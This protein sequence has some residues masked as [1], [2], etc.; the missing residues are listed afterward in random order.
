M[1]L[2]DFETKRPRML[3]RGKRVE[4]THVAKILALPLDSEKINSTQWESKREE[5]KNWK[6]QQSVRKFI[7]IVKQ[8][9]RRACV[10]ERASDHV[11]LCPETSCTGTSTAHHLLLFLVA[12]RIYIC[13]CVRVRK[14]E[15]EKRSSCNFLLN[16]GI[17]SINF[18][19]W[20]LLENKSHTHTLWEKNIRHLF[21]SISIRWIEQIRAHRLT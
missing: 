15:K 5:R 2:S 7:C 3:R 8:Y 4:S 13:V 17:E 18:F 6:R 14:Q 19:L 20:F 12:V 9:V 16:S 21:Q 1:Y 10:C 11:T